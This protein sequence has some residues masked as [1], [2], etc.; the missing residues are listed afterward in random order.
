MDA[1]GA[2]LPPEALSIQAF[3]DGKMVLEDADQH[4]VDWPGDDHLA[5]SQR[6]HDRACSTRRERA[7]RGAAGR[8]IV[9]NN[10]L[11]DGDLVGVGFAMDIYDGN[12]LE[13]TGDW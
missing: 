4:R 5:R 6:Q 12:W 1:D 9:R 10:S 3:E 7:S 2:V 13:L 11:Q 8:C